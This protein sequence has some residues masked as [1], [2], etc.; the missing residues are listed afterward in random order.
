ML[1]VGCIKKKGIL[2]ALVVMIMTLCLIGGSV[3]ILSTERLA[4]AEADS[5]V[6]DSVDENTELV[7]EDPEYS[8]TEDTVY[9][10]TDNQGR[11][12]WNY[13]ANGSAIYSGSIQTFTAPITGKYMLQAWGGAGGGQRGGY[14]AYAVSYVDLNQGDTVLILVG[15][16]GGTASNTACGGGGGGTFFAKGSSYS[17]ATVL[18]VAGGGGGSQCSGQYALQT[19][20][21]G[22]ASQAGGKP[23][24]NTS[25]PSIGYG[26]VQ[27]AASSGGGFYGNGTRG[28]Y[29]TFGYG[30]RQG[31]QG[32]TTVNAGTPYGGY[33]GGGST[34]G[35]CG[36]APG[37]GG[38]TGGNAT[39]GDHTGVL[40]GGG[41]SY[42]TGTNTDGTASKA[43]NGGSNIP[44]RTIN[45]TA[46]M[47]TSEKT[48]AN[49]YARITQLN[50]PPVNKSEPTYTLIRGASTTFNLADIAQ[51]IDKTNDTISFS[52]TTVYL[53]NGTSASSYLNVTFA[54]TGY[55]HK[56]TTYPPRLTVSPKRYFSTT[57]FYFLATDNR[58]AVG[59]IYFKVAVRDQA[60]AQVTNTSGA[61]YR[62]GMSTS[63][64]NTEVTNAGVIYNPNHSGGAR[65]TVVIPSPIALKHSVTINADALYTDADGPTYDTVLFNTVSNYGGSDS[66]YTVERLDYT[67]GGYKNI[68]ITANSS[69]TSA[70]NYEC[71]T[72]RMMT[73]DKPSGS[74]TDSTHTIDLVFKIDNT[75]PIYIGSSRMAETSYASLANS[76]LNGQDLLVKLNS[77]SGA[78]RLYFSPSDYEAHK[79]EANVYPGFVAYDI[80]G[81]TNS[82]VA[83]EGKPTHE[84]A[85]VD[86]YNTPLGLAAFTNYK[87]DKNAKSFENG[88][89]DVQTGFSDEWTL[90]V[91][92]GMDSSKAFVS[93]Y[94]DPSGK[95]IEFTPLRSSQYSYGDPEHGRLGHFYIMV[96]VLDA[97]NTTDN[98]IWFPIAI[99][100]DNAAPVSLSPIASAEGN[101]GNVTYFSP[102]DM[103]VTGITGLS[104]E[105]FGAAT[106]KSVATDI[107]IATVEGKIAN[108]LLYINTDD[109]SGVIWQDKANGILYKNDYFTVSTVDMTSEKTAVAETLLTQLD[110][111]IFKDD[112]THIQYKGLKVEQHKSTQGKYI[113]A[114]IPIKDTGGGKNNVSLYIKTN[115]AALT[116]RQTADKKFDPNASIVTSVDSATIGMTPVDV[117]ATQSQGANQLEYQ[118]SYSV[119][120]N[121]IFYITPYDLATDVD[122]LSSPY[123]FD[124]T[125]SN[126]LNKNGE[127]NT[128]YQ[129]QLTRL[130]GQAP[131]F[132]NTWNVA[133]SCGE[134]AVAATL[135]FDT[136]TFNSTP[137]I[138]GT[139]YCTVTY[140]TAQQHY[141]TVQATRTTPSSQPV[142]F[143][144]S[145]T[146]GS[147]QSI[148]VKI[149]I[150]VKNNAPFLKSE[151]NWQEGH[152]YFMRSNYKALGET[153]NSE[154]DIED[155]LGAGEGMMVV[156]DTDY[157][158]TPYNVREFTVRDIVND[159]ESPGTLSFFGTD[160]GIETMDLR[161][162][163]YDPS[164]GSDGFIS[165]DDLNAGY[166]GTDFVEVSYDLSSRPSQSRGRVLKVIAKSSTQNLPGGLFLRLD[167]TD[168]QGENTV[169]RIQIEVLNSNLVVNN[170]SNNGFT[171]TEETFG[172]VTATR[173]VWSIDTTSTADLSAKRYLVGNADMMGQQLTL[174][175]GGQKINL[176]TKNARVLIADN[177]TAQKYALHATGNQIV[178]PYGTG[179]S[180]SLIN[181]KPSDQ[182]VIT[183]LGESAV[184]F[185]YPFAVEGAATDESTREAWNNMITVRYFVDGTETTE[186]STNW[187]IEYTPIT[188]YA[189]KPEQLTLAVR[190]RDTEA[191]GGHGAKY[192]GKRTGDDNTVQPSTSVEGVQILLVNIRIGGLSI[193][194]T[195]NRFTAV[196]DPAYS[197]NTA[198][199]QYYTES[200]DGERHYGTFAYN[201]L[202]VPDN[203]AILA[204]PISYLAL[205]QSID[206]SQILR[207]AEL[208]TTGR[209]SHAT[210]IGFKTSSSRYVTGSPTTTA[211]YYDDILFE[212]IT[213]SDGERE[214]SGKNLRNNPYLQ[215]SIGNMAWTGVDFDTYTNRDAGY[216]DATQHHNFDA[217]LPGGEHAIIQGDR[218]F[219][220]LEHTFGLL[221]THPANSVRSNGPLTIKVD[222]QQWEYADGKYSPSK[223][224]G[225]STTS[226]IPVSVYNRNI[227][228]ANASS[229]TV[230]VT[231]QKGVAQGLMLDNK[232]HSEDNSVRYLTALYTDGDYAAMPDGQ[233]YR[234]RAY[235]LYSSISAL[236]KSYLTRMFGTSDKNPPINMTRN[237]ITEAALYGY[238]GITSKNGSSFT[239]AEIGAAYE[240][241]ETLFTNEIYEANPEY[242]KY[243]TIGQAGSTNDGNVLN[244][245]PVRKTT[246]DLVEAATGSTSDA[247]AQ[248]KIKK[249][250]TDRHLVAEYLNVA[251]KSVTDKANW[252][253][254]Y[255]FKVIVYDQYN[256]SGWNNCSFQVLNINVEIANSAPSVSSLYTTD[257]ISNQVQLYVTKDT[258]TSFNLVD[259]IVDNDLR[260]VTGGTT[261]MTKEQLAGLSDKWDRETSDYLQ[262]G[263]NLNG[264]KLNE[265]ATETNGSDGELS[266]VLYKTDAAIKAQLNVNTQ[267]LTIEATSRPDGNAPIYVTINVADSDGAI[268]AINFRINVV[269]KIPTGYIENNTVS[270]T[271]Y[272]VTLKSGEYFY[273]AVSSYDKLASGGTFVSRYTGSRDNRLES[274]TGGTNGKSLSQFGTADIPELGPRRFTDSSSE[275]QSFTNLYENGTIVPRVLPV[276]DDD[277]PW[278]LRFQPNARTVNSAY[279]GKETSPLD[280]AA[281]DLVLNDEGKQS[282]TGGYPLVYKI[283][284]KGAVENANLQFTVLDFEQN[285]YLNITFNITVVS[286]PPSARLG[287]NVVKEGLSL[288]D[289]Q[290]VTN[291]ARQA[292]YQVTMK[293][294]QTLSFAATD[295][296]TDPDTSDI[297]NLYFFNAFNGYLSIDGD[298]TGKMESPN[299][300]FTTKKTVG[301]VNVTAFDVTC[302]N[303]FT[304]PANDGGDPAFGTIEFYVMDP[305][306]INLNTQAVHVT[307]RI[308]TDYSGLQS[309]TISETG[310]RYTAVALQVKSRED[311]D[312]EN[313]TP[314]SVR[315]VRNQGV[316]NPDRLTTIIDDDYG[317]SDLKYDVTVY[318]LLEKD[319]SG[320]F[321]AKSFDDLY[322]YGTNGNRGT[323]G[324]K[325]TQGEKSPYFLLRW[326]NQNKVLTT[327]DNALFDYVSRYFTIEVE[328][329]GS[330]L[331]F[332]PRMKTSVEIVLYVELSKSFAAGFPVKAGVE[333]TAGAVYAVTVANSAPK[334][335][336]NSSVNSLT[337]DNEYKYLEFY[338]TK[339]SKPQEY[340][341]YNSDVPQQALFYDTD[342]GESISYVPASLESMV[343]TQWYEVDQAKARA[344]GRLYE[345]KFTLDQS[346][347]K[348]DDNGRLITYTV[349]PD[350]KRSLSPARSEA[351]SVSA[352][353]MKVTVPDPDNAEQQKEIEVPGIRITINRKLQVR[354]T[355]L[356]TDGVE[357]VPIRITGADTSGAR[358]T[359]VVWVYIGNNEPELKTVEGENLPY[360]LTRE[361]TNNGNIWY[362]RATV[363]RNR[364]LTIRTSDLVTD[365]DGDMDQLRYVN[366]GETYPSNLSFHTIS[367]NAEKTLEVT[368]SGEYQKTTLFRV[369]TDDNNTLLRI[370]GQTTLRGQVGTAYLC[371]GDNADTD[372]RKSR[373]EV[374]IVELTVANSAPTAKEN[375]VINIQGGENPTGNNDEFAKI[376]FDIAQFV[377]DENAAD[378]KQTGSYLRIG[379]IDTTEAPTIS[380]G[381]SIDVPE[382]GSGSSAAEAGLFIANLES[383]PDSKTAAD[384][385][386]VNYEAKVSASQVFY[387][388]PIAK[389]YGQQR[390]TIV[391]F[392]DGN[393]SVSYPDYAEMSITITVNVA[394][395][396]SEQK[397]NSVTIEEGRKVAI[398]S[399]LLLDDPNTG[400]K[401]SIGYELSALELSATAENMVTRESEVDNITNQQVLSLKGRVGKLGETYVTAV[402]VVAGDEVNTQ[403][404]DFT[405]NVIKNE[406]PELLAD[407]AET[408]TVYKADFDGDFCKF[409]PEEV[410]RDP[411]NGEMRFV[412]ASSKQKMICEVVIDYQLNQMLLKF[413]ANR[414]VEIEVVVSDETGREVIKTITV[415][416]PEAEELGF[417][418]NI[419]VLVNT[420]KWLV[421]VIALAL[422]LLLII[423][424]II[425]VAVRKKRKMRKEIEALLISEM[426]LEE[427]M[428]KLSAGTN[429]TYYQSFGFLPPTQP[430]QTQNAGF[431]LGSGQETPPPASG[432]IGLNPGASPNNSTPPPVDPND[433]DNF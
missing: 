356:P 64:A 373:T 182:A 364:N 414:P 313:G 327:A 160:I 302:T 183:G 428:L 129:A 15:K 117:T 30:F 408:K 413:K 198:D 168:G 388:R 264:S 304:A 93:Y 97:G 248:E 26:G 24:D 342:A 184:M 115:N 179:V 159:V 173:N 172:D 10:A 167:V 51:D 130:T 151:A 104:S 66:I 267:V 275:V 391:I 322:T 287:D 218:V 113:E 76:L 326:D 386:F 266:S 379:Y 35:N 78:M 378:M 365:A 278:K 131:G 387:L 250:A 121:G 281:Y 335:V 360:T 234:D 330:T 84:F 277:T 100:V 49:G 395:A 309:T 216:A 294:G 133:N 43:I 432:A 291:N 116:V 353:D 227:E 194:N 426:E 221:F 2:T 193:V 319:A 60:P 247:D 421:L 359:N 341:L 195:F 164:V 205:P 237:N 415:Q 25:T 48:K 402:F 204:V 91:R 333:Q 238:F 361:A 36:G 19:Q 47:S 136:L 396:V 140:P 71:L 314:T 324:D 263:G 31:G 246:F 105:Q 185:D 407:Y 427:Q 417:F 249:A 226:V 119:Y 139:A 120:N 424:I 7:G 54:N 312:K 367:G 300:T 420:H 201:S 138:T 400:T 88:T 157:Y 340:R 390:I 190:V 196:K 404:L 254:Y 232:D 259:L 180:S 141:F 268:L 181:A 56:N 310:K 251:G 175:E 57:R 328:P 65:Y 45:S 103:K 375:L 126:Y 132:T 152:V 148:S 345:G 371:F 11:T 306:G 125:N 213:L 106:V 265:G 255:P 244:F 146:D 92:S 162:G 370:S 122:S 178:K 261:Y 209:N 409:K 145:I 161:G 343:V 398:T 21:H 79:N 147:E 53:E 389:R 363:S 206:A 127:P 317:A 188:N 279:V 315:L 392:D 191:T 323:F 336:E 422:L 273:I 189:R 403:K 90:A 224:A 107:D 384:S 74:I 316:A 135:P 212:S 75:R 412:R 239:D 68:K 22:Q 433:L 285:S 217:M 357:V 169:I 17:S 406:D 63:G 233:I 150:H 293:Y 170:D 320:S 28:T 228:L 149:Q 303:I 143:T 374:V 311:Y 245:T 405:V 329:D 98:G 108:Q 383:D 109:D 111:T 87:D 46:Y 23:T 134:A 399:A 99:Q 295:F 347:A 165:I 155:L 220:M 358:V 240:K 114:L 418:A 282:A 416:C 289:E 55:N 77:G 229:N 13:A 219:T 331:N 346:I 354:Q 288:V 262:F 348:T 199:N 4:R 256:N 38:Y 214:W 39:R 62:V 283:E 252:K 307:L 123:A 174:N 112:N 366:P 34:H 269:N 253:I 352:V 369:T 95:Y 337:G 20:N 158:T 142:S 272:T 344:A 203:N 42:W 59:K 3:G 156:P 355:N 37:G 9:S 362:L 50:S 401:Y 61:A 70:T 144:V 270:P 368:G 67:Q 80:D 32:G 410:F 207:T 235:F 305:S 325:D 274:S 339:G 163:K 40:G 18:C 338:G 124:S 372:T 397:L 33:G 431:M 187:L 58:G 202:T 86:K 1:K 96:R 430:T 197:T 166:K 41:G 154:L 351:L 94:L 394:R 210:F 257:S 29:G 85:Y 332:V 118:V 192:S 260:Q 376:H 83:V 377:N 12:Y 423:L 321:T 381:E 297:P 223:T 236:N 299:F 225:T 69:P 153:S 334:A 8:S 110:K 284:A 393:D 52:G 222:L 349:N 176:T 27:G 286:T 380:T 411:E 290:G 208:T 200:E 81:N 301:G 16:A 72:V 215:I 5:S 171:A 318:A 177:D 101:V 308:Y 128:A 296:V 425:I 6:Q 137:Q 231:L 230:N 419:A 280:I 298:R 242:T 258:P 102:Y 243:F 382:D 89:S 292:T 44:S 385:E 14:G 276:A 350:Y 241:I 211:S 73:V 186:A 429:P 82:I 271:S